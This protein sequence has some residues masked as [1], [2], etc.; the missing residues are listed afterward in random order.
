[1]WASPQKRR[2]DAGF[3]RFESSDDAGTSD[4][5]GALG[6]VEG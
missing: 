6:A 2:D 5:L 1:V 3:D 4:I